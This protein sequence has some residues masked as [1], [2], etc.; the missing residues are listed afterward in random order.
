ML[1]VYPSFDI[2]ARIP[3]EIIPARFRTEM[4]GLS[5]VIETACRSVL[6]QLSPTDEILEFLHAHHR[7][8]GA[9]RKYILP[10]KILIARPAFFKRVWDL[11]SSIN[12]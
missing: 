7:L 4:I 8:S 9:K 2:T 12:N 6:L 3:A 11:G 1:Y 10:I 5:L